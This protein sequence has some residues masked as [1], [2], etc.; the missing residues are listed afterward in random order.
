MLLIADRLFVKFAKK[1]INELLYAFNLA[2]QLSL[3]L[4]YIQNC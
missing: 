3:V 4:Q 1:V 2:Y